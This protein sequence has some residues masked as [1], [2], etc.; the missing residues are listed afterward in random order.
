[1]VIPRTGPRVNMA[2][3]VLKLMREAV[4]NAA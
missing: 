3:D 2:D 1:M 4:S